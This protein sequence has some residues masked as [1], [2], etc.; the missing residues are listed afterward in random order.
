MKLKKSIFILI[1]A[2]VIFASSCSTTAEHPG[3]EYMPDMGHSIAYESNVY[4][5]YYYNTWEKASVEKGSGKTLLELSSPRKPIK[6]TIA[7]GYA[8]RAN[9]TS[10][11]IG[12]IHP[13]GHVPFHYEDTEADRAKASAEMINNPYPI[14]EAALDNGKAMYN[15]FCATCHGEKANGNGYLVRDDGGKYPAQPANL[16]N[17]EFTEASNGRFYFALIYG[18]NVM[19]G[20]SDKISYEERWNVIHYIRSLQAKEYGKRY[21]PKINTLSPNTAIPGETKPVV[22]QVVEEE[23]MEENTGDD[24]HSHEGDHSGDDHNHEGDHHD[25]EHDH[26]DH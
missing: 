11:K 25:G 20:Y 16:I 9:P 18:K 17:E 15:I 22:A 12:T 13:N 14:T 21:D 8:G 1:V 3:K 2:V 24:D 19:G 7:R 23:K 5:D 6:G 26:D 10:D 4:T